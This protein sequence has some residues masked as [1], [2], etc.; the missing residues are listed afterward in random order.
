MTRFVRNKDVPVFI[1]NKDELNESD[2]ITLMYEIE[3]FDNKY[4]TN[5][6]YY[7]VN[8]SDYIEKKLEILRMY[9]SEI[10]APPF[11][12]NIETIRSLARVR[13]AGCYSNYAEAFR[14]IQYIER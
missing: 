8:I 6:D 4:N 1:S 9:D 14:L 5:K 13:G 12:R 10:S 7:Y 2:I 11:P 3:K